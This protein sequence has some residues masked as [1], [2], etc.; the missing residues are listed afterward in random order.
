MIDPL[1]QDLD[2]GLGT[3]LF[4]SWHVEIIH[5][6]Y[7][8]LTNGWSIHTTLPSVKRIIS[9]ISSRIKEDKGITSRNE[10]QD[11]IYNVT[12]CNEISFAFVNFR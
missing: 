3:I 12:E 4:F 1:S 5:K 6:H 10:K 2:G 7:Y 11:Y 8:L 9:E